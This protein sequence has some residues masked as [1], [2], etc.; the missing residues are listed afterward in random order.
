V[1]RLRITLVRKQTNSLLLLLLLIVGLGASQTGFGQSTDLTLSLIDARLQTLRDSTVT[2]A[3]ET[4]QAYEVAKTRLNNAESFD[5]DTGTNVEALTSAPRLE[6]EIQ[7]RIDAFDR[8]EGTSVELA[9]LSSE[10]LDSRLVL[11]RSELSQLMNSLDSRER[12][13]AG[14][15]ARSG[16]L[17]TRVSEISQRLAE[18]DEVELSID[19]D[20]IPSMAEALLWSAAAEYMALVAERRANEAQLDSQRVRYTV[21][22]AERSELS[23][24]V[25]RL[26]GQVV[27]LEE[28]MQRGLPDEEEQDVLRL[29]DD[30]PVYAVANDMLLENAQLRARRRGVEERVI[31]VSAQEDEVVRSTRALGEHFATARRMVEFAADS[32]ILGTVLIAHWEGIDS[33][34]LVDPTTELSQ[35]LGDT[36]INRINHEE[37]L[38]ATANVSAY[39]AGQIEAAGLD[40]ATISEQA[41]DVLVELA[42]ARREHLRR[43]IAVESDYI[44]VLSELET[45]YTQLT[46]AIK[47]YEEYLSVLILWKPSRQRIWNL[48]LRALPAEVSSVIGSIRDIRFGTTP[49]FF[50]ALLFASVLYL[51]RRRIWNAQRVQN[52][53]ILQP[54]RDSIRFTFVALFL[55][56]LRSLPAALLII[57]L[58][59][60]IS[61]DSTLAAANLSTAIDFI[62]VLLFVLILTSNLC[63]EFGVAR[64]HFDWASNACSLWIEDIGWLIRW[65]LPIAALA[66]IFFMLADSAAAVGRLVLLSAIGVLIGRLVSN[67]R[68]G[69]RVSEWRWSIVTANRLR[70]LIIGILLLLAAGVFW[71]LR[72]S[73][74]VITYSL[75]T[76]VYIGVVLVLVHGLLMRWLRVVHRRLRFNDLRNAGTEKAKG[77]ISS[78]EEDQAELL[79]ISVETTQLLH[80]VTMVITIA[81]M[82]TIWAPLFPAFDLLSGITLWTSTSLVKGEMFVT[83]ITLETL[84]IVVFLVGVTISAARHLP[85]LV[86]LVLRARTNMT[87]GGRYTISTLMSYVIIG[88][89]IISALSALGLNWSQLQWLV[90][91][92]GVGI[93]FGLQEIVANFISGLIILFERPIRV[94]DIV[95]VGDNDGEVTKIRIRATTIRDVDGKELLVPNKEFIT[96]RLLNWTLTDSH[97]RFCIPVG[98]A[99]GSDVE[100]ALKILGEVAADD[101]NAMNEPKP[102][103]TF[104]NFG[105]NALELSLRFFIDEYYSW[106][107]IVTELRREIYKRFNEAG[108]V[109]AYPQRDVHLDSKQPIKIVVDQAPAD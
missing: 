99:Y 17:R 31:G 98:I 11:T 24:R 95:T 102:A 58:G 14:R 27:E 86:E 109:I 60:L 61:Q 106:R 67:C 87:A 9:G 20:A 97:M 35:H 41:R 30:D 1:P 19:P 18:I 70:V 52:A 2:G 108:I 25:D 4:I 62:A 43:F 59:A 37:A 54:E 33:Y 39:I 34:R 8:S 42:R 76:S 88:I 93:G 100:R 104:E 105:D 56:G 101:P 28:D 80:L 65:W 84:V 94:G 53:R 44:F 7:S 57:A 96:G 16:L 85:A 75:L 77:D 26:K 45:D 51:S 69:T 29:D 63:E 49:S 15:E 38:A 103:I 82:L 21:L 72:Y 79:E 22:Q 3:D 92:L 83:Q 73:V 90:A 23:L 68:S 5:R 78:I 6:A 13:L 74:G 66:A 81:V 50:M 64:A 55:T 107:K 48:N 32:D 12:R 89:G 46:T 91:A 47:E 71:G 36:V 10:E 40:P